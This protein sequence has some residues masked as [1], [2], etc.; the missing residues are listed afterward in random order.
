MEDVVEVDLLECE[1]YSDLVAK[2]VK[3]TEGEFPQLY[4]LVIWKNLEK[5][6][7]DLKAK[8]K[9]LKVCD[10]LDRY[11]TLAS[12]NLGEDEPFKFGG[13]YV[14]K[15]NFFLV[16]PIIR[17]GSSLP[18]T[19][20]QVKDRFWF[21]QSVTMPAQN[22]TTELPLHDSIVEARRRLPQVYANPEIQEY[23]CSLLVFTRTHRLCSLAPLSTRPSFRALNG[24]MDFAK[25]LVVWNNLDDDKQLF[26]TPE[27]IKLA[28]RKI[29]YWLVD[30]ETNPTFCD[31]SQEAEL[32][33]Q[34][35]IS[36]L[37]GDWYGSEWGAASDYMK[38]YA[39]TKDKDSTTG[40]TNKIVEEVLESVQPP[41]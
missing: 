7:V 12:R 16:V 40:F 27:Y 8:N 37:T 23:I 21:C 36:M 13:F 5:V 17:A 9:L 14:K 11:G 30:W 19:H 3:R 25:T 35:E 24:I 32:R 39:T 10:E 28:Y 31:E 1:D 22:Q 15:P 18:K 33:K 38:K 26:V 29:G 41:I 2:M 20:P 4:N 6:K 34:T